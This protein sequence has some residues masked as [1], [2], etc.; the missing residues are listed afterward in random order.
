MMGAVEQLTGAAVR[1]EELTCQCRRE[2]ACCYD[3]KW[4]ER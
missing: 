2:P 3:V 1:V 4:D